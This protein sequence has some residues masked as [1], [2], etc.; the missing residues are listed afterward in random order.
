MLKIKKLFLL[1]FFSFLSL[2]FS[3]FSYYRPEI[4]I[5]DWRNGLY[6]SIYPMVTL[7]GNLS[8]P[9]DQK[10]HTLLGHHQYISPITTIIYIS[11]SLH[12][13]Q[14][15]TQPTQQHT[16]YTIHIQPHLHTTTTHYTQLH[17]HVDIHAGL[18]HS[19]ALSCRLMQIPCRLSCSHM[20]SLPLSCWFCWA[21]LTWYRV[22]AFFPHFTPPFCWQAVHTHDLKTFFPLI[23]GC[24]ILFHGIFRPAQIPQ[25][26]I[27]PSMLCS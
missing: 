10:L 6:G 15:I 1:F 19:H 9:L 11:H 22:W 8:N 24:S 7:D 5:S 13:L 26:S 14:Y 16:T 23:F 4:S 18:M 20:Y 27:N 3:L 2:F 21:S 12:N 25:S 17:G